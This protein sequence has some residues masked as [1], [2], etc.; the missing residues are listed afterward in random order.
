[1][2]FQEFKKLVTAKAQEMGLSDYELY[3]QVAESVIASAFGHEIDRFSANNAGGVCFRCIVDGKM[4]YAATERLDA[5]QAERIVQMAVENCKSL[6]NDEPEFLATGGQVYAQAQ[7][8]K[9]EFP[10][11]DVL[12]DKVLVTQ[13]ALYDADPHVVDGSSCRGVAERVRT[14]I[15]NSKGLDL[16]ADHVLCALMA[17]A[18]VEKDGTVT[19]K[20]KLSDNTA[21][22]TNP[23]FKKL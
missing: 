20:I 1:M 8:G 7:P 2:E 22:I 10:A 5:Q 12:I 18:V 14:A 4:G 15:C 16:E 13:Q 17:Q 6:E 19:P 9:C 21:K 3:Y 11:T 23:G